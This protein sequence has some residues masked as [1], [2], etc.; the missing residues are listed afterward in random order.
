MNNYNFILFSLFTLLAIF[1]LKICTAAEPLLFLFEAD[2]KAF[3]NAEIYNGPVHL[4]CTSDERNQI[5]RFKISNIGEYFSVSKLESF[6]IS[7]D[8]SDFKLEQNNKGD[9]IV[10][11]QAVD[12]IFVYFLKLDNKDIKI[13]RIDFYPHKIPDEDGRIARV[14]EIIKPPVFRMSDVNDVKTV[15]LIEKAE[16][17]FLKAKPVNCAASLRKIERGY[18]DVALKTN[19]EGA[20]IWID[21]AL[22]EYRTNKTLRFPKSILGANVVFKLD[23]YVTVVRQVTDGGI[24]EAALSKLKK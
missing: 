14:Y 17:K 16:I 22:L 2:S 15:R 10:S 13:Q 1:D 11:N 18:V 6:T 3:P 24:L 4:Y 9:Y 7:F 21:G 20:E 12:G 5:N 23:G 8:G 19:P